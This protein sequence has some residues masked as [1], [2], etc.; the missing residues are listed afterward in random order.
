M[1]IGVVATILAVWAGFATL[2]T[3]FLVPGDG[4]ISPKERA[5]MAAMFALISVLLG[6]LA[7]WCFAKCSRR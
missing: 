5:A 4:F 1:V 3:L 7:K 2:N 6:L